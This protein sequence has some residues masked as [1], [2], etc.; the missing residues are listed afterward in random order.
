MQKAYGGDLVGLFTIAGTVAAGG[1]SYW[2]SFAGNYLG[3]AAGVSDDV[4]GN[5]TV[6]S[7]GQ[8]AVLALL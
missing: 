7:T 3:K 4:T 6:G 1:G 5:I 2:K 8:F